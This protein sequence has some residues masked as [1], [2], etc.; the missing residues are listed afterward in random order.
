MKPIL[1]VARALGLDAK[2]LEPYGASKAKVSLDAL[3]GRAPRGRLVLVS[4]ITPTPA[5]EG[6]T[7]C[8]IGL[9]QG[10]ARNGVA[11]AVALREPS[12]G[13]YL[14]MKGGGTGGGK[15][16]V[17]PADDINLHFTGDVHAVSSAHNLL[18]ALVDNHL[19]H[20]NALALDSRR[21][22]WRRVIDM[23]DRALRAIVIGLGGQREGVPRETGFDITAASEVMAILCLATDIDDL[24][25]RLGRIVVAYRADGSPVHARDLKAVGAMAALL[26]DALKPNLVQTVEGVPA[27]IHGGPFANIAHG[28]NSINATRLALAYADLV[29]TEAGFAFELGAEKFFDINCR[30]GNFAPSATLLVATLRALK[31]HGGVPLARVGE[32]DVAG[33]ER[34]LANLEKHVEN[35][36]KFEQPCVVAINQFPGD[37][38]EE[39]DVVRARC[40][41]LGLEAVG[42]D[43]FASGGEGCREVADVV[44]A[45]AQRSTPHFKPLYEWDD[46]IEK[47]IHTVAH[48]MYGAEAVDYTLRAK[49]ARAQ[50]EKL[51]FGN[52]P[53]CIAKTQQ[54]LSDN[55]ALLGR[56][57][58]FLVTVRE[59]QLAA[60]AGFVVPIT[61]E[62]L[63]MP[64]LPSEPLATHFDLTSGGEI[65]HG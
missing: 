54:S 35:I 24:K 4:A 11:T 23:N 31:M 26:R 25:T 56:P 41:A 39:A 19:H 47:K 55:P 48:E 29:V 64:G 3:A 58:D 22:L 20:G 7:T 60:G 5:G 57:K 51:G 27:L 10:L 49:R 21:V 36:R 16:Q 30:Y 9:A 53:V 38:R 17:I 44:W 6:K 50:L 62:I 45:L 43:P 34:G 32:P 37:T 42:M 18:A 8:S 28:T 61:G 59:I 15:S 65:V 1:D 46:S 33:V 12:L 52:L 13:P 63:R 40:R 14:G 2:H